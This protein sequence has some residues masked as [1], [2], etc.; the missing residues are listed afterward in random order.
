MA[1]RD[2]A[3]DV[4]KNTFPQK[5]TPSVA[6]NDVADAIIDGEKPLSQRQDISYKDSEIK[7]FVPQ[8]RAFGSRVNSDPRHGSIIR[9]ITSE[10]SSNS[11]SI[12]GAS[13]EEC[14]HRKNSQGRDFCSEFHSLCAKQN[15]KRA[16]R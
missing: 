1:L 9:G 4:K 15:C 14:K 5:N 11:Q 2:F 13:W 7:G 12:G 6:Q 16:R 8:P 3:K 10:S